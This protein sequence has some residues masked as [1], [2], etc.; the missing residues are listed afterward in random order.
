MLCAGAGGGDVVS[1]S[2]WH[3][4]PATLKGQTTTTQALG[5]P[6]KNAPYHMPHVARQTRDG[7]GRVRRGVGMGK[8]KTKPPPPVP[9][10]ERKMQWGRQNSHEA[11][12][13][14]HQDH[15]LKGG[16]LEKTKMQG[17]T[18]AHME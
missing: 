9:K 17:T 6:S 8:T 3:C 10:S 12:T 13:T 15:T 14:R 2:H 7:M 16:G 5:K 4:V 11:C 1:V 18:F